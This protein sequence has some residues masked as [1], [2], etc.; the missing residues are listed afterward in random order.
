M[1]SVTSSLFNSEP[2]LR[3]A[4]VVLSAALPTPASAQAVQPTM[5][6]IVVHQWGGPEVLKYQEAPRP[7]PAE[8]EILVRIIAAGVNPV[9]ASICSGR[10][11]KVLGIT[12]PFVPGSDIAGI[13]EKTGTKVTKF[14]PGDAVFGYMELKRGGGYAQY[15][16]ARETEAALKPQSISFTEAA[17]V[18]IAALTAWQALVDTANLVSGQTVL[19]HGG[20]GGVGTFAIQ[21]AKMR[22]ARVIATASTQNQDLLKELGADVAIDYTKQKFEDSARDVDVVLDSVGRDTL[23]RSYPVAKKGG[24]I[25]S[26]VG[27]PD[28]AELK[29][30]GIRGASLGVEPNSAELTQ[31]G[32]LIDAKKIRVIVSQTFPLAEAA[33]A[34]RQIATHHTRGKIVLKVAEEPR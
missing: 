19:V 30:H 22:G 28:P 16:V 4:A 11:A 14:K 13:V 31:I 21:I 12:L 29:K 2:C 8:D 34:Q 17:A 15:A 25:V 32:R 24:I 27:R 9:D 3:L 23:A 1:K 33:K 7:T 18:P 26:I 20:S 5:R 10:Y 6:A